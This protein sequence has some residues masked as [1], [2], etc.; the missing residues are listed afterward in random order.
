MTPIALSRSSSDGA[1]ADA[2][3]ASAVG[4]VDVLGVGV[5]SAASLGG[6]LA[7]AAIVEAARAAAS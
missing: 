5:P 1:V 7:H 3:D 4:L 6:L 2:L